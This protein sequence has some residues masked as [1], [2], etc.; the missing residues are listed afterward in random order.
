MNVNYIA[1]LFD[2]AGN[3]RLYK[4]KNRSY[5][6]LTASF[7]FS[8]IN[9]PVLDSI[10][11]MLGYG[12]VYQIAYSDCDYPAYVLAVTGKDLEKLCYLIRDHIVFRKEVVEMI[13]DL[14]MTVCPPGKHLSDDDIAVREEIFGRWKRWKSINT[15]RV[16]RQSSKE[17]V[18]AGQDN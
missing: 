2:A 7:H 12:T 14:R 16:H 13:I 11:D 15:F 3:F 4:Y 6:I 17:L 9:K 18:T 5:E 1:G 8:S 10:R